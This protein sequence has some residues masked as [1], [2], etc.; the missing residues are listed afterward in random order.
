MLKKLKEWMNRRTKEMEETASMLGMD[1]Q[2]KDEYG[3]L[4][5]LKDFK[6]FKKGT[7]KRIN[8][9]IRSKDLVEGLDISIFDYRYTISTGK[10]AHT[11]HQTVF[12]VQSKDLELPEF[13]MKPEHFFHKVAAYL[14]WE[15]ID[16]ESHPTFSDQYHLK[17]D[18]EE[19][20]RK[21]MN[22][23]VLH[24]FTIEK[25][26]SLEGIGYFLIF[27]RNKKR[28]SKE[29]IKEFCNKGIHITQFLKTDKEES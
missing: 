27:Y 10:S 13:Y 25:E 3:M 29:E 6:L 21:M 5:L 11:Y 17:G 9:I 15:D 14:G 28:L 4:S 24:F 8:H 7:S 16:F 2:E 18:D 22:E 1:Y 23:E 26:W 19:S 12:F 20:I